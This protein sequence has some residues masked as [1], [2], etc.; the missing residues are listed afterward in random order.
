MAVNEQ[1]Q[2]ICAAWSVGR[3]TAAEV[4]LADLHYRANKGPGSKTPASHRHLS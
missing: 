3:R 2:H 1:G 4:M